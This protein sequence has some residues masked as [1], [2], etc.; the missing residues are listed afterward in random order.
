M[1]PCAF[2]SVANSHHFLGAVALLNSLRLTGHHEALVLL[3]A[4]LTERQRAVLEPHVTLLAP[5]AD[6]PAVFLAP[7]GPL[8]RPAEVAVVLDADIIVTRSLT[9]LIDEARLGR[10]VAFVNDPPNHDRF[11]PAWAEALGLTSLRRRAYVNAGQLIFPATLRGRLL[12]PWVE[13]QRRVGT[14]MSRY[15]SAKLEDPFYFA[16]QDVLNAVLAA[17]F[18]DEE[19]LMLEHRLAPHP[20]FRGL[21]L[22]DGNRLLCRYADGEQPY[23]L[24]HVLAKPWLAPTR[25]TVYSRLLSRLLLR[26]DVPLRIDPDELPLRLRDGTLAAV[27]RGAAHSGTVM[28]TTARRQLGRFGVRTRLAARRD[29]RRADGAAVTRQ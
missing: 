24:H 13:G 5:P 18:G 22:E 21:R 29:G 27:A 11:F 23:L 10:I 15:G 1:I 25:T 3:D 20:P 8:D 12:E 6:T 14:E 17:R 4:G 26:P 2:Y 9:G 19:L 7:C 16:D 28:R